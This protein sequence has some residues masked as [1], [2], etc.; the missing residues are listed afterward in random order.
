MAEDNS[1]LSSFSGMLAQQKKAIKKSID[2][3]IG[4]PIRTFLTIAVIAVSLAVPMTFYVLYVNARTVTAK[5]NDSCQASL[6][7][8]HETSRADAEILVEKLKAD[9]Y[10]SQ[11]RLITKE[12]GLEEFSRVSGLAEPL[13]YLDDNPLP[14]VIVVTP[15]ERVAIGEED[16]AELLAKLSA[17]PAVEQA[18]FDLMWVKRL[19]GIGSLMRNLAVGLGLMLVLGALLTV[20]NTIRVNVLTERDTVNVMRFFGATDAFV[21]RPYIWAGVFIGLLGGLLAWWVN[22]FFVLCAAYIIEDLADLYGGHF[23]FILVTLG[24][25]LFLVACSVLMSAA[26]TVVSLWFMLRDAEEN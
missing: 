19:E 7:L 20:A 12:E 9:P 21:S 16:S 2:L 23:D 3:L 22:E 6:Y 15:A 17:N 14:D 13:G 8:K 26:A 1:E 4:S 5:L 24:E 25:T 18:K 11:V 10:I